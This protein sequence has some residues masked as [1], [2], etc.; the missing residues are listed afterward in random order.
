MQILPAHRAVGQIDIA[1]YTGKSKE[2]P[3]DY[4]VRESGSGKH[5]SVWRDRCARRLSGDLD[6]KVRP[7]LHLLDECSF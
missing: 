5:D 1:V 2:V 4:I 3:Y 7:D 6:K